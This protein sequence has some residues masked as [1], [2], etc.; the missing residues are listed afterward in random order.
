[1]RVDI[2]IILSVLS[3]SVLAK[4]IPNDGYNGPLLVRRAVGPDTTD[5]LWKRADDDG[6]QGPSPMDLDIGAEAD[7]SSDDS[8]SNQPS[9]SGELSELYRTSNPVKEPRWPFGEHALTQRPK[10]ILQSDEESIQT[11]IEKVT[12]AF[13][14]ENK[15]EF[16]SKIKTVLTIVLNSVRV[17]LAAYD[18]KDTAPFVLMIPKGT[19]D[20]QSSIEKI[21]DMQ[22]SGKRYVEELLGVVEKAISH[23]V[24]DPRKMMKGLQDI[25]CHT[26]HM[27][28]FIV[29][30]YHL[31]YMILFS[32][33]WSLENR[34]YVDV[35]ESYIRQVWSDGDRVSELLDKIERMTDSG[36]IKPKPVP[37]IFSSLMSSIKKRLG[38]NDGPPADTTTD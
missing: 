26:A 6:E 8:S 27:R 16:I 32:K 21:I 20:Q 34:A 25:R 36:M 15:D 19:T 23:T 31:H 30:M 5:L 38:I 11:V 37:S 18:S 14:G 7:A 4:A 13:E 3:F 22:N 24:K 12:E 35:T 10:Y 17:F 28:N 2:G 1:M 33:V 9:G 29:N